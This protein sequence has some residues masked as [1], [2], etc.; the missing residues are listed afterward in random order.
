[1]RSIFIGL[2]RLVI[3]SLMALAIVGLARA[4]GLP[5]PTMPAD[6]TDL[7]ISAQDYIDGL[8]QAQAIIDA[9]VAEVTRLQQV[10]ADHLQIIA[11]QAALIDDL[12]ANVQPRL[13]ALE[14]AVCGGASPCP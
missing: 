9:Y 14:A 6:L 13:D 10:E 8:D 1:M 2:E 3:G 11:D 12:E 5:D 7:A 4:Q